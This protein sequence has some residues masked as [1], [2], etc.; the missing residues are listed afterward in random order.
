[1][2]PII[3][4]ATLSKNVLRVA[5]QSDYLNSQQINV[6]VAVVHTSNEQ[7]MLMQDTLT[8][9]FLSPNKIQI[10]LPK[11][12]MKKNQLRSPS[13]YFKIELS[14]LGTN[15]TQVIYFYPKF[16]STVDFGNH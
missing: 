2:Q 10:T 16:Q 5:F 4:S 9:N 15:E 7:T 12:L 11:K 3:A 1:Y 6:Q 14:N 8:L 13:D